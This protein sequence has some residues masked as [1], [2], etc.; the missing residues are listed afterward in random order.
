MGMSFEAGPPVSSHPQNAIDH[1]VSLRIHSIYNSSQPPLPSSVGPWSNMGFVFVLLFF[2]PLPVL[3]YQLSAISLSAPLLSTIISH[4]H[5]IGSYT[6]IC[7]ETTPHSTDT[8]ITCS[9]KRYV[10]NP[11][12]SPKNNSPF[13]CALFL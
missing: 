13:M 7:R 11:L 3:F 4:H 5:H 10:C 12:P 2:K 6:C 8:Y 1:D 9:A